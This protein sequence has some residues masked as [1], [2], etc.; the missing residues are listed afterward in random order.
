MWHQDGTS[1]NPG[2]RPSAKKLR[3]KPEGGLAHRGWGRGGWDGWMA[4]PTWRTWVWTS[5]GSW[6]W[7]GRPV[8]LQSTG[9]R[10]CRILAGDSFA[11]VTVVY[12]M[13]ITWQLQ[14]EH[15]ENCP[16][17]VQIKTWNPCRKQN[18]CLLCC[19][20][21][22]QACPGGY[23]TFKLIYS[24]ALP[25]SLEPKHTSLNVLLVLLAS[26]D[27]LNMNWCFVLG[28]TLQ[29]PLDCKEIQPV[30][31]KGDQS[32]VFTGRTD[33]EAEAPGLCPSDVKS[34]LIRKDP[35]AGKGWGQEKDSTEDEMV[36]WHHWL[37]GNGFE[38]APG[39]N[40][41]QGSLAC[42]SPRGHT[43]RLSNADY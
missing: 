20:P 27:A 12:W 41:G 11:S 14:V 35:D 42:C 5:S 8:V 31:C 29:S 15:S 40:E 17:P 21:P 28:E 39:D 23:E 4:S 1:M 38:Q 24:L 43:E 3:S 37:N 34:W 2:S 7:T 6:W 22:L 32:W 16:H 19:F 10:V 9:S 33:A 36:G 30:H 18:K 25:S 26:T 13:F